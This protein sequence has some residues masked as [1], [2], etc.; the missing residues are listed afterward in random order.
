MPSGCEVTESQTLSFD[1]DA[2]RTVVVINSA[3][4]SAQR[5]LSHRRWVA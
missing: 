2:Q 1:C 4:P 3:A 5:L